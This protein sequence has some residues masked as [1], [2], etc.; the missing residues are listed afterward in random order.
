MKK[1]FVLTVLML[2]TFSMVSI[3]SAF[4]ITIDSETGLTYST[5]IKNDFFAAQAAVSMPSAVNAYEKMSVNVVKRIEN[6]KFTLDGRFYLTPGDSV[7]SYNID[8]AYFQVE[9]GPLVVY[10]GKQRIK[11]GTGY[12]WN[13]SDVLQPPKDVLNPTID[14]EGIYAVRMEY[15]NN[16]VTPSLIVV[17]DPQDFNAGFAENFKIGL[18]LYKLLGTMDLFVNSVYQHEGIQ[19]IGAA[20]S[21]DIDLFILNLEGAAI[22]YMDPSYKL[23]RTIGNEGY[24]SVRY[25][26]MVGINR[27]LGQDSSINIEY[28]RN[29]WGLENDE[30]DSFLS[31]PDLLGLIGANMKKDYLSYS[32]SH[33]WEDLISTSLVMMHG[34]NDGTTYMYPIISYVGSNNFTIQLGLLENF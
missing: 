15:S 4:E 32:F 17:I 16:I 20:I 25:N 28:Y 10:T 8:N 19:S 21:W 7:F 11:W 33:T 30:F 18:Q 14:L 34:L 3:A 9:N 1:K 6:V 31:D 29:S 27:Q 12:A 26:F 13:P 23:L 2:L 22:R 24:D 5:Y